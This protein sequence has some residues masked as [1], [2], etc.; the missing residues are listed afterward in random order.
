MT[1]KKCNAATQVVESTGGIERGEF[2]ETHECANGHTGT[3]S[4]DASDP[5][6]LWS[7]TGE[8]FE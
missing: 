8:V 3:V 7:R 1:C 4:G 2:T 5:P 6:H